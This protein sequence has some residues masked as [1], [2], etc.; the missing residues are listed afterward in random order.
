MGNGNYLMVRNESVDRL[1]AELTKIEQKNLYWKI[2]VLQK[3]EFNCNSLKNFHPSWTSHLKNLKKL[4]ITNNQLK[5]LPEQIQNLSALQE[6]DLSGNHFEIIPSAIFKCPQLKVLVMKRNRLVSIFS[7]QADQNLRK[8]KIEI[9][10]LKGNEIRCFEPRLQELKRL[11]VL[12]LSKNQLNSLP[13][14][15]EMKSLAKLFLCENRVTESNTFF[16]FFFSSLFSNG[17]K[18]STGIFTKTLSELRVCRNEISCIT[19]LETNKKLAKS[20]LSLLDLS[21]NKLPELCDRLFKALPKLSILHLQNNKLCSVSE[22]VSSLKSLKYLNIV[23]FYS[24]FFLNAA[25]FHLKNSSRTT[26]FLNFLLQ[27]PASKN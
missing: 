19:L 16:S 27:F 6:V 25:S 17:K 26:N 3:L 22:K 11:L 8:C 4:I 20:N 13:N 23:N 5:S 10:I 18:V 1:E 2:P 24:S 21:H 14:R 9:L 7:S 12:D 15:I